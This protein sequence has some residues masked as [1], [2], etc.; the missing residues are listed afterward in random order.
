MM[1]ENEAKSFTAGGGG[2]VVI[3]R[4]FTGKTWARR[5]VSISAAS[6]AMMA[7]QKK[8]RSTLSARILFIDL[9]HSVIQA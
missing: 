1:G 7:K 6:F 3:F 4:E 8:T 9:F 5:Y 2:K